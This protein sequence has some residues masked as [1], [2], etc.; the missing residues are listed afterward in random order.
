MKTITGDRE[1]YGRS[2]FLRGGV[3]VFLVTG[4]W[5]WGVCML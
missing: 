4:L 2:W 1:S 5:K 3:L